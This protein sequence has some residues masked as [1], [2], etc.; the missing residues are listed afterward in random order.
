[1]NIAVSVG[2]LI[3]LGAC[4]MLIAN[5]ADDL[6]RPIR[7]SADGHFLVQPDGRP[8]FWL[9]DTAWELF[10]R[11]NR[12]E[13]DL[14]LKDRAQKGFTVILAV[15]TG[16]VGEGTGIKA[17]NRYGQSPFIDRDPLQPN[18]DYF[19][20]VDWAVDRAAHYGLRL[21]LLPVWGLSDV[22]GEESTRIA[23]L[24]DPAKAEQYGHW[25]ASRYRGKGVIWVL[26]GDVDPL[27]PDN[28]R[29]V[30]DREGNW[31][32]QGGLTIRDFRPVYDALAKGIKAGDGLDAFITYHITGISFSGTAHPRTS[33][34]FH[35]RE[36][37]TMNMIQSSHS[38][39]PTTQLRMMGAD[40]GWN[41]TLNYE[42]IGDEYASLPARPVVDSEPHFE[43]HPI[44]DD[45]FNA[46]LQR[47]E[48]RYWRAYDIRNALY[49]A[50]FAGAAGHA[51]G[52][53][54]VWE[55]Y[56]INNGPHDYFDPENFRDRKSWRIALDA[57]GAG[58][59]HY[60]KAL[61]L[62][63]P[64]FS[65][66]PDQTV[67]VGDLGKGEQHLS[68]TRDRDGS[69]MMIYLPQGGSVVVDMTRLA[70]PVAVAWWFNPRTGTA[71]RIKGDFS[72][73]GTR[74]FTPAT[75]GSEN[76]WVLVLDEVRKELSAPG[77]IH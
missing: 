69:Y 62:S 4:G 7:A 63:R 50:L 3:L 67:I 73:S 48:G 56:D 35:D 14:Y 1:M 20:H 72:T 37:L 19:K 33:L 29:F 40:F 59:M 28:L 2:G 70:G 9:S 10:N 58:Q 55:F 77:M 46:I 24:F 71:N 49:H 38:I 68:A 8:F 43:D 65:R 44:V 31:T 17:L 54:N 39:D 12:E 15:V 21:A 13:T 18:L 30:Q 61:M 34:Y 45:V 25:L 47:F 75:N 27:W 36:W 26:G 16:R 42:P 11:L 64:Y 6:T 57:P 66:I 22:S 32:R 74:S 76:D 60:A 23:Q 41:S 51:Y 53:F 52:H 5:A